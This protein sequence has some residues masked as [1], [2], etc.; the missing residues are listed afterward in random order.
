MVLDNL[1]MFCHDPN[2]LPWH[3]KI[4]QGSIAIDDSLNPQFNY[5]W[6]PVSRMFGISG[7][8]G[9]QESWTVVPV[10][11]R[12]EIYTLQSIYQG[13]ASLKGTNRWFDESLPKPGCLSGRYG[14]TS[15]WVLPGHLK[16]LTDLTLKV[17]EATKETGP[18]SIT[19]PGV[20]SPRQ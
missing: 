7:S 13:T 14:I 18:A 20:H 17:L 3:L 6:S 1:A 19:I 11:D 4:T 15:V 16:D 2:S 12:N 10:V 5:T 8:R 9:W